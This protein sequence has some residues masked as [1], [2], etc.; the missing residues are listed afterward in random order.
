MIL[1][2][3]CASFPRDFAHIIMTNSTSATSSGQTATST[4]GSASPFDK[5]KSLEESE[6]KRFEKEIAAMNKEKEEVEQALT[7]KEAKSKEELKEEA[8]KDLK[9]FSA[10]ELS[11]I[12]K[13]AEVDAENES[14]AVTKD[15]STKKREVAKELAGKAKDPSFILAP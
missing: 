3:S 4:Q 15:F 7:Q 12:L 9:E 6:K 13:K 8:K 5:I 11:K 10:K 1:F 14:D 2:A